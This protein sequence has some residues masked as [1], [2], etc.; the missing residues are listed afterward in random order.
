M[1]G[2]LGGFA[3][4]VG[5]TLEKKHTEEEQRKG[6][7]RKFYYGALSDPNT[8]D[9]GREEAEAQLSKLLN[10]ESKKGFQ[11][12]LPLFQ[13]VVGAHKK[14]AAAAPGV[15]APGSVALPAPAVQ[16][17]TD[18][19][20]SPGQAALPAPAATQPTG[21]QI[22][23]PPKMGAVNIGGIGNI[24]KDYGQL[25][26]TRAAA[27]VSAAEDREAKKLDKEHQNRLEE[28]KA[29]AVAKGETIVGKPGVI[30]DPSD[31][32]PHLVQTIKSADGTVYHKDLGETTGAKKTPMRTGWVEGP[33]GPEGDMV[34]VLID[35]TDPGS[36]FNAATGEPLENARLVNP[37]IAAAKIRGNAVGEFGNLY[38][39]ARGRGL[40]EDEAR[41]EAGTLVKRRFD[42]TLGTQEQ[43]QAIRAIES[44]V[45]GTPAPAKVAPSALPQAPTGPPKPSAAKPTTP[46]VSNEDQLNAA[47]FLDDIFGTSKAQG[48]ARA[49]VQKGREAIARITGLKPTDISVEVLGDKG[50]AKALLEAAQVA[51]AFGRIQETLKEHGKVLI[52]AAKAYDPSGVP[53]VNHTLQWLQS[54]VGPHPELQ[55]YVVALNAVQREYGRLIAG[56]AQSRAMLPVSSEEKGESVL[57]KDSTLADILASVSQLGIEADTE[58]KAFQQQQQS[59]KDKLSSGKIGSSMG[60]RALPAPGAAKAADPLGILK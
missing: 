35:P 56:G 23:P 34:Q 38:R 49:R 41:K 32:R 1:G 54:N 29:T 58:Q 50:T 39:A 19:P 45:P 59:L 20:G 55:R 25:A 2:F 37:Q 28:I 30:I 36:V 48:A 46:T 21:A 42:V 26:A 16:Q 15:A 51:G 5:D 18:D 40:S 6:E 4:Q 43:T 10:P 22:L 13:Q 31:G 52:D 33:D 53:L 17:S 44:G 7:L 27:A 11:K 60:G 47:V 12:I 9:A 24:Y 57:R 8:S 3:T 14:P